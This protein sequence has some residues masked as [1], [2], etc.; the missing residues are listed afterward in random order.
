MGRTSID[1]KN[2]PVGVFEQLQ[3]SDETG[4]AGSDHHDINGWHIE[5]DGAPYR[6][7]AVE[8]PLGVRV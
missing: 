8:A 2:A 6:Q 3:G 4:Q 5:H 1:Q 7:D